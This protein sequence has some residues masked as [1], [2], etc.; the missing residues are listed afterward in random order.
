M[1]VSFAALAV[2][3]LMTF[4]ASAAQFYLVPEDPEPDPS[5]VVGVLYGRAFTYGDL[6]RISRQQWEQQLRGNAGPGVTLFPDLFNS[7]A[8]RGSAATKFRDVVIDEGIR[9]ELPACT[10]SVSPEDIRAFISWWRKGAEAIEAAGTLTNAQRR[11]VHSSS[12]LTEMNPEV[13]ILADRLIRD[14]KQD[15]CLTELMEGASRR[16]TQTPV[17]GM[18]Q[19][20][21]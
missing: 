18:L 12:D 13:H 21:S 17:L 10:I 11:I 6:I 15:N 8:Q 1:R 16:F 4:P 2:W 14:W 9:R 20:S 7:H 3:V 5:E 19:L